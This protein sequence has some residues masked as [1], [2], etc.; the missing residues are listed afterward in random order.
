VIPEAKD[1]LRP[2]GVTPRHLT[3]SGDIG[4]LELRGHGVE[5]YQELLQ[6]IDRRG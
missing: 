3:R 2:P 5:L 1:R 4:E 6:Q